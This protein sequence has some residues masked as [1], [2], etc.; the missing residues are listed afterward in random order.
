[1]TSRKLCAILRLFILGMFRDTR[2]RR[3]DVSADERSDLGSRL[4]E[5]RRRMGLS[6]R[7]VA[8]RAGMAP[9]YLSTLER[10]HSSPTLATLHR[11]LCALGTDLETFF[12]RT[13]HL[14]QD[15]CVFK[16]EEMS[17]AADRTRRY[18]FLL[19]R[20]K[21][22]KAEVLD[23]Y[24]LPSEPDPEFEVLECDIAG[25]VLSGL[26]E[27]EVEGKEKEIVRAGDAFYVPAGKRHRG[28]CLSAEPAH[29]ITVF[30][31]PKY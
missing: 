29:L 14:S 5:W 30:V 7:S 12:S 8:N 22:M 26:L 10:G 27:I 4:R 24:L 3:R 18:T 2:L 31:P 17:T 25:V 13:N 11:L 20:R 16:R 28:R 1:L 23:E 19:P 21:E 6:L 9:S 15:G